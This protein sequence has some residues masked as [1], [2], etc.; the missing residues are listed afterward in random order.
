[1]LEV[2]VVG[3]W[4]DVVAATAAPS[5]MVALPGVAAEMG[6]RVWRRKWLG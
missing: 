2:D 4:R 3:Q 5:A 6:A 1:V